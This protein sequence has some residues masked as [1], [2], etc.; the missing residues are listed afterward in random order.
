MALMGRR[1][2]EA[3]GEGG[4]LTGKQ[5]QTTL[6]VSWTPSFGRTEFYGLALLEA[7]NGSF[8][9]ELQFAPRSHVAT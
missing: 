5:G 2:A 8:R 4:L 9:G 1:V 3:A 6:P 7:L